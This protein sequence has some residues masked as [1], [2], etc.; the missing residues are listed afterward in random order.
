[1]KL[2]RGAYM[3][4]ERENTQENDYAKPI[5]NGNASIEKKKK[6]LTIY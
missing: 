3:E 5:C 4:K 1:M 6:C 2:V